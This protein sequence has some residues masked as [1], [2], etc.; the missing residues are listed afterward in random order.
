VLRQF[1]RQS[2]PFFANHL[3]FERFELQQIGQVDSF[4]KFTTTKRNLGCCGPF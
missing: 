4:V 3:H 1:K 2:S